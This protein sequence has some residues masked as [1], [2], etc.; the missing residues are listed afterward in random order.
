MTYPEFPNTLQGRA[1]NLS[2]KK[3]YRAKMR[4]V[5]SPDLRK[6]ADAINRIETETKGDDYED[7]RI[8]EHE[9]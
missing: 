9:N 5:K 6:R 1:E 7:S 2:F 4:S 3:Y 8:C